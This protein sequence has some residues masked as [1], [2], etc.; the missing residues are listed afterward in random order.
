[1]NRVFGICGGILI[2]IC[3]AVAFGA[4]RQVLRGH[5]P[6]EVSRLQPIARLSGSTNLQLAI[7]LPL[8]NLERL[9]NLLARIYDASSPDYRHYLTPQEFAREFG[10]TEA[11]YEALKAFAKANGFQVTATHP[12]RVLL[13]VSGSVADIERTFHVAIQIYQHPTEHHILCAGHGA[14]PGSGGAGIENQ[15]PG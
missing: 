14:F 5:I 11:D 2:L 9:T 15:R 6:R 12:N 3:A 7:G 1:M 4:E 8:R 13:D 10:P